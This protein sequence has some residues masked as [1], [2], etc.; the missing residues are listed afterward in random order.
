MNA[1]L[2][3]LLV[4]LQISANF[5][6]ASFY[7]WTDT[8]GVIHF[9]DDPDKIPRPYQ[10]KAKELNLRDQPAPEA[11]ASPRTAPATSAPGA[12][13][14]PSEVQAPGGHPEKW[15]RSRF[16]ALRGELETLQKG[17]PEKRAALLELRR[18]RALYGRGSDREAQSIL[19]S[20]ISADEERIAVLVNQ[21]GLLEQD[22][23]RAAVPAE[24]RR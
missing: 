19:Q 10:K 14:G 20:A 8:R 24:W 1:A 3:T 7:Q 13:A 23:A 6:L 18:K 16:A 2:L 17:L 22:A 9:T 21:I 12:T 15:W 11:G 5:A 4:L